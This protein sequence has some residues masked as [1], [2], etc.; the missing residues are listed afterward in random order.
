MQRDT[1]ITACIPHFQCRRYIR[2]AVES[3]LAQSYPNL[4]VIVVND[5]DPQPPWD[6][7]AD[8][9]D[10]RLIRFDLPANRGPYFAT[11]IVLRA[12]S[13]PYFLI[14]DADDWSSPHRVEHLLR[15]LERDHSDFAIS[16]QPQ[17][18]EGP[19]GNAVVDVRWRSASLKPDEGKF[20]VHHCLT[21]V[22]KYRAPHHGLFRTS[23]LQAIGGY[24]CGM[25]ISHDTL[26]PN[27]ILMTGR[28]SHVPQ[29]LY[30]RL[31]RSESLTHS[32]DTGIGSSKAKRESA[33]QRGLYRACFYYYQF[34]RAGRL[35][36]GQLKAY[37]RTVCA[38]NITPTDRRDLILEG[39]RLRALLR[40]L[41]RD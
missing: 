10:P 1:R 2:R 34:F 27:L 5:G 13:T 8:I 19:R 21:P 3:L 37:I 16:A 38:A 28:I 22:Y 31:L 36:A 35:T 12:T 6:M 26:L 11:E 30:Y 29:G 15:A 9:R 40:Q 17:F 23:S 7:L 39:N 32:S 33:I 25:R 14:Q 4:D 24:Y 20:I 18:V 41:R